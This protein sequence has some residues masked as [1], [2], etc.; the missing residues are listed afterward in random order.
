MSADVEITKSIA[1]AYA[2]MYKQE[3]PVAEEAPALEAEVPAEESLEESVEL[4]EAFTIPKGKAAKDY[5]KKKAQQRKD[6]NKKNDPGAAK[7]HLALSVLD[8]QK[9]RAKAKKKGANPSE[10]EYAAGA[11][12]NKM[13]MIQKGL[14][15]KKART[16]RGLPEEFESME[17]YVEFLEQFLEET[18]ALE[19]KKLD[20]VGK[21]DGDVDN[22]G[23]EDAADKYLKM[24]RKKISK[25]MKEEEVC[26]ECGKAKCE[27]AVTEVEE[28]RAKGEK[29]FK[30]AH[31]VK[32][33]VEGE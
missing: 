29:D 10:F 30:D 32:K 21:E 28:P 6:M 7:K 19:E 20:P 23:D 5:T 27:C 31:K 24:R 13:T 2:A 4:D 18:L 12:P 16:K 14:D 25:A 3:E 1:D 26:G 8:K 22:D 33:T 9:A 15:P 17:D 11:K